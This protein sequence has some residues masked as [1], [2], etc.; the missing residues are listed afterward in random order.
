[1]LRLVCDTRAHTHT[2][3]TNIEEINIRHCA[4]LATCYDN[5]KHAPKRHSKV[6]QMWKPVLAWQVLGQRK[7]GEPGAE[8]ATVNEQGKSTMK[9]THFSA[10]DTQHRNN[11][12]SSVKQG[13]SSHQL[14]SVHGAVR[15]HVRLHHVLAVGKRLGSLVTQHLQQQ[16][17]LSDGSRE[18]RHASREAAL[19]H[20]PRLQCCWLGKRPHARTGLGPFQTVPPARQGA[21]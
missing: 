15:A 20:R 21:P 1:M 16:P 13:L 12:A 18:M 6:I 10:A 11:F 17:S 4:C 3:T 7:E 2:H 5:N 8:R 14:Q 19:P 9:A